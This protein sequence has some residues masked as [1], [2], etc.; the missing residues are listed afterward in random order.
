[1]QYYLFL[2][3][4][5]DHGLS[6]INPEFPVFLLC[7]VIFSRDNYLNFR[8][9]LNRLKEHFWGGNTAILHSRDVRKC[10]KE[11]T[12]LFDL[13]V[14]REFYEMLNSILSEEEYTVINAAIRKEAYV[15]RYGRLSSDVYEIALSF[16]I[17]R[18]VF[19]LDEISDEQKQLKIIIE[20]RGKKEDTRLKEHFQKIVSRGT[21]YVSA[22][23]VNAY[24]IQIE[25]KS[26]RENIN[27]LQLADLIAYPTAR[28][29][30]DNDRANPAFEIVR[31]KI[32][33][34]G[35]SQYGLKVFP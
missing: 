27:G 13:G 15:R 10:E 3:E 6:T 1:M 19:L 12:I 23:R 34:K 24:K 8:T 7:G 30:L 32:Y 26:K 22:A 20:K 9:H 21:G 31:P 29:V 5:G 14:K 16:I 18:T 17:E 11:F 25:F 4:S 35:T 28:Y 33:S 2:D